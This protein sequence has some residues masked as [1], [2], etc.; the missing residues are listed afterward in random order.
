MKIVSSW[1]FFVQFRFGF[2]I[3]GPNGGDTKEWICWS[4]SPCMARPLP[5]AAARGDQL[6]QLLPFPRSPP[7]LHINTTTT[8]TVLDTAIFLLHPLGQALP[9]RLPPLI[10][11]GLNPLRPPWTWSLVTTIFLKIPFITMPTFCHNNRSWTVVCIVL[12]ITTS[13]HLKD[14]TVN[15]RRHRHRWLPCCLIQTSPCLWSWVVST[16]LSMLFEP[17]NI[18]TICF[19]LPTTIIITT[20][21][22]K[23][24]ITAL[25]KFWAILTTLANRCKRTRIFTNWTTIGNSEPV[26]PL[27]CIQN[28]P[29]WWTWVIV[30]LREKVRFTIVDIIIILAVVIVVAGKI[31]KATEML[32]GDEGDIHL[33]FQILLLLLIGLSRKRIV[34]IMAKL[35]KARSR[36]G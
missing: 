7:P 13:R 2:P 36:T 14:S 23:W 11:I 34:E 24:I 12:N 29:K 31:L 28:L 21:E 3:D 18:S 33:R 35:I 10:I 17:P 19:R 16:V 9:P 20:M 26:H 5:P 15:K 32:V 22:V 6:P 8:I 1:N 27:R 25:R 4:P 30:S